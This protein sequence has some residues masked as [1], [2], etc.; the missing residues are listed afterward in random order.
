MAIFTVCVLAVVVLFD[1][2][3]RPARRPLRVGFVR[4]FRC[5]VMGA[6]MTAIWAVYLAANH[7]LSA[8]IAFFFDLGEGHNLE[9]GFPL[10]WNVAHDF[11]AD[12]WFYAPTLLWWMTIWRVVAKVR[13]RRSWTVA[14]WVMVAA[15]LCAIAYVP[16]AL[17]RLEPGHAFESFWAAVPLL[18]LWAVELLTTADRWLRTTLATT[19]PLR[20]F[21]VAHFAT[22]LF[23]VALVG[24]L[25]T[26]PLTEASAINQAP[27]RFHV[28]APVPAQGLLGYS[29]PGTTDLAEVAGLGSLLDR[30]AGRTAPVF[31][32][33][34]QPGVVYY[35]LDRVPGTQFYFSDIAQTAEAQQ[36]VVSDLEKSRPPV[37]IFNDSSFGIPNYDGVPDGIRS[38]A[39]AEYLYTHYTPLVDYEG[40]LLG[41]RNDLVAGAPPLP[42]LP[43]GTLT[44]NLYFAGPACALGD[45]PNFFTGPSHPAVLPH[46]TTDTRLVAAGPGLLS[47][48]AIDPTT[49]DPVPTVVA[50][51]GAGRV[52]ASA[53][54]GFDR[55]DVVQI[56]PAGLTSGF[57]LV[58]PEWRGRTVDFLRSSR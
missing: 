6:V 53:H 19:P 32:F 15:A 29:I 42:P 45:I 39:I 48:W 17:D 55:P 33:S 44:S 4:T 18:V 5:G 30:Y 21:R 54:T 26:L 34:D 47:G 7:A 9:G 12:F 37:A 51:D 3:T 58:A 52:V 2:C 49:G 13:L 22:G 24:G 35:L 10:N 57:N 43:T 8:F 11:Q 1:V 25:F 36:Q 23:T 28:V 38:Y 46:V 41:L 16:K 20:S 27:E 14:D 50:T 40:Q 56:D 31:D